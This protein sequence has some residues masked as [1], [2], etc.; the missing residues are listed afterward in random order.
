MVYQFGRLVAGAGGFG[1]ALSLFGD[2]ATEVWERIKL[3]GRSLALSLQ[4]VWARSAAGRSGMFLPTTRFIIREGRALFTDRQA[5]ASH[6]ELGLQ[7]SWPVSF[8]DIPPLYNARRVTV[9]LECLFGEGPTGEP[10]FTTVPILR[11]SFS[12][13]TTPA[14][15]TTCPAIAKASPSS[16]IRG[17]TPISSSPA[18]RS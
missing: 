18:P 10:F 9:D 15:R 16:A 2:V 6:V 1:E 12:A 11:S 8:L 17:M 5:A 3:G 4:S 7:W 14:R 13:A